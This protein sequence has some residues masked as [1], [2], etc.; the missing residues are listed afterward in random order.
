ML[1]V[2]NGRRLQFVAIRDIAEGEELCI[3]YGPSVEAMDVEHRQK[4]LMDGWFFECRCSRCE[5]DKQ[6]QDCS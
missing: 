5:A 6:A 2:R 3:S 1:K 4:E